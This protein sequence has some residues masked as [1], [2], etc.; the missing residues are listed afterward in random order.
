MWGYCNTSGIFA[1]GHISGRIAWSHAGAGRRI[2]GFIMTTGS[3]TAIQLTTAYTVRTVIAE[4]LG[5][6]IERVTDEAHFTEDFGADWL[7]RLEL[8]IAIEDQF[9]GV[10]ITDDDV[11]QI[12]VVG[13]LIRHVE[14]AEHQRPGAITVRRRSVAPLPRKF[15]G[16]RSPRTIWA[17]PRRR[18]QSRP[19]A[20]I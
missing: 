5:V 7:D 12:E 19:V 4:H 6:G 15:F 18:P 11:D 20:G 2:G 17:P 3:L 1:R 16:P 14:S 10:E 9:I 8:M 13:D